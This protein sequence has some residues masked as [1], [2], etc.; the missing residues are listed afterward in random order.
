M[1]RK[2][3]KQI[4]DSE[5][6]RCRMSDGAVD[7]C[8]TASGRKRANVL[9]VGRMP[10]SGKYQAALNNYLQS[11]GLD[12]D[13]MAFTQA[14]KCRNFDV[15]PGKRDQKECKYY[16][17]QEITLIKPEW[18]LALGNEALAATTGH[19]GI[20]KYRG[21]IFPHSSGAKVFCTIS[22]ASVMRN[23]GQE[24]GYKADLNFFSAQVKGVTGGLKM[25]KV[26]VA[27]NWERL[28]ELARD[29]NAAEGMSYD[30]ET[31]GRD[32]FQ[33]EAA[34]VCVSFT[35][36]RD[37]QVRVWVVPLF[38]PESPWRE[39][40][41]EVIEWLD[42][43]T[44]RPKKL[45]AQ[46]G[47]FDQRWLRRFGYYVGLTFDT[48]LVCH[49]LDE[50][51]Q[52]GLK[53][54]AMSRLGVAPWAIDTRS[55]LETPLKT[56]LMY[57]AKDTF[58]TYHLYLQLR[59]ELIKDPRL[60]RIYTKITNPAANDLVDVEQHGI[61]LDQTQLHTNLKIALDIR[62]GLENQL[63]AYAPKQKKWPVDKKGKIREANF[64]PSIWG[65]WFWFE[66]LGLPVLER[67][68]DKDDGSPGDPS[69]AE[70][71]MKALRPHH[72]AVELHLKRMSVNKNIT[73]FLSP[74]DA[75]M[76]ENGRVRT[77]FK[78]TGTVTGRLSSGK[79]DEEKVTAR[80]DRGRGLN[81]Q[82]VPR[83]PFI[84]GM[85][86]APPGSLFVE[87][88]FSQIE[89]RIVAF[90]SRDRRMLRLYQMG[91]DIHLATAAWIMGKPVSQITK[92][93]R[94]KAKAVNFGFAYGM[95]A[96]KFVKTALEKYELVFSLDEAQAIRKSFFD[97]FPGLL[98]WHARQRRLV[99]DYKYVKSPIGRIRHLPDI[100]SEEQGVRAEAERQAIN[101]P[102]QGFGSDL[103]QL[104]MVLINRKVRE[105]GLAKKIHT[106]GTV[107]DSLL[108][109]AREAYAG[110]CMRIAKKTMENLPL[111][112]MFGLDLD[113]PIIADVKVG[114]RWGTAKE[115]T[116]QEVMA[117]R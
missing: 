93:D 39:S 72:P 117:W 66:H 81:I 1:N 65:R 60:T 2:I 109:E 42:R 96:P 59:D 105:R 18:I 26:Q 46:N 45:V 107:H 53:P 31:T 69:M 25:P 114:T 36:W 55:L 82:Q 4:R 12:P 110:E 14:I 56:V 40:W 76:D 24:E 64:N 116:T 32:E 19:S 44:V 94:K 95:G 35:L 89:L 16:L 30:V 112:R 8:V 27:R 9:V 103:T 99:G 73:S 20:M 83:D 43:H 21:K 86:G 67:G 10:N 111:E 106:I 84:R 38:H 91:E 101:S 28:E 77:T 13:D 51:R 34:I 3:S 49:L 70:D 87:S 88:D 97:Q 100:D 57:N 90:L 71:V 75:V 74:Y 29:I 68:K 104:S 58:Y 85:F 37:G 61:W 54:Q 63:M 80:R 7:V 62:A 47:K 98:A 52:K 5:C 102:V 15:N 78:V 11:A 22:P 113:V 17:D 115:L 48:M 79:A 6:T 108:F 41:Q 92:E 33:P 23:P 50:N